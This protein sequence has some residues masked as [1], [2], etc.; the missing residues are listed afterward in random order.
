[1]E[2]ISGKIKTSPK[3]MPFLPRRPVY[4]GL[5]FPTLDSSPEAL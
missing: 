1:M 4:T 3:E 2:Q 5:P